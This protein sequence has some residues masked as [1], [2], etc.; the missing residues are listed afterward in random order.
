MDEVLGWLAENRAW[1]KELRLKTNLLVNRRLANEISQA[2]YLANRKLAHEDAAECRRR[3][4]ILDAQMVRSAT[5]S[6]PRGT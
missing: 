4:S 6:A 1:S 3:A 5:F 2:D